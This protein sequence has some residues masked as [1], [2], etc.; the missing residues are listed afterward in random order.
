MPLHSLGVFFLLNYVIPE[1]LPPLLMGLALASGGSILEPTGT[2]SVRHGGSFWEL[3]TE[4]T[5]VAPPLPKPCTQTR[6]TTP[7]VV[8]SSEICGGF[9]GT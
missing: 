7:T 8:L 2:G 4:A 9:C 5:P 3:L 1:A 6:N